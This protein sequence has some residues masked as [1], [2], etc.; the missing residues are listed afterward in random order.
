MDKEA[1][2]KC[3]VVA[4]IVVSVGV[5]LRVF[6]GLHSFDARCM[7]AGYEGSK[8]EACKQRLQGGIP[9]TNK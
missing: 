7:E 1:V 2:A 3:F 6:L 8:L 9:L 5:L 4:V